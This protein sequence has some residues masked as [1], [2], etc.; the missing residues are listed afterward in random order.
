MTV[1]PEL[2]AWLRPMGLIAAEVAV[3]VAL[4]ALVQRLVRSP[5]GRRA[6]WQACVLGVW[7]LLA[8][9]LSGVGRDLA[10]SLSARPKPQ[11]RSGSGAS[12]IANRQSPIAEK[13]GILESSSHR[14]PSAETAIPDP[15]SPGPL[16]LRDEFRRRVA[17]RVA[18]NLGNGNPASTE[19]GENTPTASSAPAPVA[20]A[21]VDFPELTWVGFAWLLGAGLLVL[22]VFTARLLSAWFRLRSGPVRDSRLVATAKLLAQRLGLRL[23]LCL[24]ESARLRGPIAFGVLRPTIILPGGFARQF[25]EAQQDAMLAHEIAHLAA[26]DP[27]WHLLADLAAALLWWH[28]LVWWARRRLH[29]ANEAAADLASVLVADGPQVLAECLV[30]LGNRL[31]QREA[32]GWLGV[33]GFRSQLGR[34]VEHLLSLNRGPWRPLDRWRSALAKALGALGVVALTLFGTA[35]ALPQSVT[36]GDNMKTIRQ[37]WKQSLAAFALLASAASEGFAAEPAEPA[38]PAPAVQPAPPAAAAPPAAQNPPQMDPKL[39]ERYGI[40]PSTTPT[41]P[42][43]SK[44]SAEESRRRMMLR[45]G[46]VPGDP[47]NTRAAGAPSGP[48]QPGG[49]FGGG[50][51]MGGGGYGQGGFGGGG[52]GMGGGAPRPS[53][54][55]ERKL[56]EIRLDEVAFENLSLP[57]VLQYLNEQSR[58]RD[59]EKKG[60]NFLINPNVTQ[61]QPQPLVDPVTGL[62]IPMPPTEPMVPDQVT[63]RFSLPLRDVRLRDVLD[64]V[65]K[66]A[67]RPIR[68]SVEDYAVVVSEDPEGAAAAAAAVS[69]PS[70]Q[71]KFAVR[72]FKVDTNTILAGLQS[73]FGVKVDRLAP[74][75]DPAR[76]RQIR[77]AFE[78]LFSQLR[79]Q[80]DIPGKA[81]FYNELTGVIMV[82]ATADE[83]EVVKAAVETLGGSPSDPEAVLPGSGMSDAMMRRYGLSPGRR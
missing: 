49:G 18:L 59:P 43:E 50:G 13:A 26:R 44:P 55:L 82:R 83:L 35:W 46:L 70:P 7:V 52:G 33:T 47:A 77:S 25:T 54:A 39:M 68:Y 20:S 69:S 67:D 60:I 58:Q 73:A 24:K 78:E 40:R 15:S 31:T 79:I 65:V 41:A 2:A 17:E 74:A 22:R 36:Q 1:P 4:A 19:S 64:A 3:L 9:E 76:S 27:L 5:A 11:N 42:A 45:Y 29:V 62:V 30:E 81:V 34:R 21:L 57:T 48:I 6:L 16:Q 23:S 80:M 75:G 14:A 8:A 12:S 66:V 38:A 61:F 51:G 56:E 37:S 72:T 10:A 71:S 53:S 28:P 32:L 63:I